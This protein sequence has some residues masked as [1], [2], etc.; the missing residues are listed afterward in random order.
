MTGAHRYDR[1]TPHSTIIMTAVWCISL[2]E[3]LI[4]LLKVINSTT[5]WEIFAFKMFSDRTDHPK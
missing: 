4:L 5:L 1:V 2:G 3:T